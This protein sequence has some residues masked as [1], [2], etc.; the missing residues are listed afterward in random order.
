M[1]FKNKNYQDLQTEKNQKFKKNI[2][3]K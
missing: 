1:F 3:T 2:R